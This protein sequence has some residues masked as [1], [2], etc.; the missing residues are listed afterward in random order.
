MKSPCLSST[1][2]EY[3]WTE[4]NSPSRQHHGEQYM[5]NESP[6]KKGKEAKEYGENM[7]DNSVTVKRH[8]STNLSTQWTH[9]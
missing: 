1:K 6:T 8:E 4:S 2:N 7:I 3:K 5:N 9:N